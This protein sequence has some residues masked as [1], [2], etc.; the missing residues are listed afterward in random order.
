MMKQE[1]PILVPMPTTLQRLSGERVEG[2]V[3]KEAVRLDLMLVV[4]VVGVCARI[5]RK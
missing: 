1:D 3:L 2:T 5:C 4:T